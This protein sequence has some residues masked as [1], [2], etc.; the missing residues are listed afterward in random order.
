MDGPP[1]FRR[2]M[3]R[4]TR[5]G[6]ALIRPGSRRGCGSARPA[7]ARPGRQ[8]AQPHLERQQRPELEAEVGLSSLMTPYQLVYVA[9]RQIR[10]IPRAR[11]Q[12]HVIQHLAKRVAKPQT[13]RYAETH[14]SAA[15]NLRRNQVGKRL[16]KD[17]FQAVPGQL[18]RI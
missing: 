16:A 12:Q 15:L 2:V 11:R 17:D 13:E 6:A 3:M 5:R 7:I 18:G 4:A 9:G 14:L 10:S 1:M 8:G